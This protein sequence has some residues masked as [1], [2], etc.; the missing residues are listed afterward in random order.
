MVEG[1]DPESAGH[2][3]VGLSARETDVL[4]MLGAG[5]S[6]RAAAESLGIS[7]H[8]V[9][10]HVKH[11]MTKLDATTRHE[12]VVTARRRGLLP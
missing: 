3:Y 7:L 6:N 1:P 11:L 4:A 10:S 12:A 5:L 8:T 9:K 2:R